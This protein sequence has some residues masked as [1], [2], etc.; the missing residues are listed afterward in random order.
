[1]MVCDEVSINGI[2]SYT[3]LL[4]ATFQ[5]LALALAYAKNV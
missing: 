3:G 1:M 5:A 4:R 2:V